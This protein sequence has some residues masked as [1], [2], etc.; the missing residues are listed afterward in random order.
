ML[1][2]INYCFT[3]LRIWFLSRLTARTIISYLTMVRTIISLFAKV[4]P[5]ALYE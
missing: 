3:L 4:A 2:I 5:L 1:L